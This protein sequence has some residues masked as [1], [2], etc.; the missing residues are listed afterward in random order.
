MNSRI[1][2][3]TLSFQNKLCKSKCWFF[4]AVYNQVFGF[5]NILSM[6]DVRKFRFHSSGCLK[7]KFL[8]T[9]QLRSDNSSC[10]LYIF[11]SLLLVSTIW[12][13]GIYFLINPRRC[14]D[15]TLIM[16]NNTLTSMSFFTILYTTKKAHFH[17]TIRIPWC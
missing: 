7:K 10:R 14:L 16:S 6:P 3:I 2:N 17:K 12:A 4:V 11:F 8:F 15:A 9:L 5:I 1:C 13:N